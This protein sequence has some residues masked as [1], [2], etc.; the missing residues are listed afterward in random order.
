MLFLSTHPTWLTILHKFC[1]VQ[2]TFSGLQLLH[3]S[4]FL[5]MDMGKCMKAVVLCTMAM[6]C[7]PEDTPHSYSRLVQTASQCPVHPLRKPPHTCPEM[8]SASQPTC[9][10]CVD[11]LGTLLPVP[12]VPRPLLPTPRNLNSPHSHPLRWMARLRR[13]HWDGDAPRQAWWEREPIEARAAPGH[14]RRCCSSQLQPQTPRSP[15]GAVERDPR[16]S[17]RDEGSGHGPQLLLWT[18]GSGVRLIANP[19]PPVLLQAGR[20]YSPPSQ[21]FAS[22]SLSRSGWGRRAR[23]SRPGRTGPRVSAANDARPRPWPRFL[24]AWAPSPGSTEP[25]AGAPRFA[26][27][28]VPSAGRRASMGRVGFALAGSSAVAVADS[29]DHT[30]GR[31]PHCRSRSLDEATPGPRRD[32]SWPHAPSAPS[33]PALCGPPLSIPPRL[34]PLPLGAS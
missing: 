19:F 2:V 28:W 17:V 27:P 7:T 5:K 34:P 22:L 13:N 18:P 24:S 31:R 33:L 9:R 14:V 32:E 11:K 6:L 15:K 21:T 30:P 10:K 20:Y 4:F 3:K 16:A 25:A 29:G 12:A 26:P 1:G 23:E 8:W